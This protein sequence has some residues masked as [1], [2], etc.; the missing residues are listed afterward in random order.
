MLYIGIIAIAT[1]AVLAIVYVGL[2][3]KLSLDERK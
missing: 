2:L 3:V 1:W